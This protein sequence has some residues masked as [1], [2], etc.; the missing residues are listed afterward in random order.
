MVS[1]YVGLADETSFGTAVTPPATFIDAKRCTLHPERDVMKCEGMANPGSSGGQVGN[2]KI[3]GE[4]EVIPTSDNIAKLLKWLLGT[5]TTTTDSSSHYKHVYVPSDVKKWGTVY[6]SP[7][8]DTDAQQFI[9]CIPIDWTIEG[10]VGEPVSTVFSLLGMKDAKVAATALGTLSSIR[11]FFSLDA[12]ITVDALT[13]VLQG[14]SIKYSRPVADDNYSM[15]DPFLKGFILGFPELSG[16][17]DLMFNDWGMY[18]KFWGAASAPIAKPAKASITL[19]LT[20][21]TL[22]GTGDYAS[23]LMKVEMPSVMIKAFE[24][25]VEIRDK[26]V[27]SAT[28]DMVRGAAGADTTLM[29]VTLANALALP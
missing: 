20:G 5:P 4:I 22:G 24:S 26:I 23:H 28:L 11:Q 6:L 19:T 3:V 1:R 21:D 7:D 27:Q 25:P 10:A 2:Y 17:I 13:A 16:S 14:F 8:I 29:K 9:S 18:G 12:A 15:D